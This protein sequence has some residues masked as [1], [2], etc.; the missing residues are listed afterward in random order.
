[1]HRFTQ[2][3]AYL[4][5]WIPSHVDAISLLWTNVSHATCE[6][7]HK[8]INTLNWY[9][10]TSAKWAC[11]CLF[12]WRGNRLIESNPKFTDSFNHLF[13]ILI[14]N[15]NSRI[16]LILLPSTIS[17]GWH[18]RKMQDERF[19]FRL[20]FE[21]EKKECNYSMWENEIQTPFITKLNSFMQINGKI[22]KI[23]R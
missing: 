13:W 3:A 8:Q 1:M 6:M 9:Y 19:I 7:L 22:L 12:Y 21:T 11:Y 23:F 20:L 5:I 2:N 17:F 18:F 15:H 14:E 4:W 16:D 10:F